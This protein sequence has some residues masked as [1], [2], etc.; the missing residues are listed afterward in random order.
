MTKT[1]GQ[2]ENAALANLCTLKDRE[3]DA[4]K[5]Q[6]VQSK[7]T[8]INMAVINPGRVKTDHPVSLTDP[9]TTDSATES[10]NLNVYQN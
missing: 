1:K 3:N 6:S 9:S 5:N 7:I 4:N 8:N 10:R 2:W